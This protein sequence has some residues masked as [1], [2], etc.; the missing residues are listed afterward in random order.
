MG[1]M[2]QMRPR[3]AARP[4]FTRKFPYLSGGR[5]INHAEPVLGYGFA[6]YIFTLR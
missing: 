5:K 2:Y 6:V 1:V 3:W 4:L